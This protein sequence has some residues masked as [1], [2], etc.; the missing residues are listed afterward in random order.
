MQPLYILLC[1]TPPQQ[2]EQIHHF[3]GGGQTDVDRLQHTGSSLSKGKK[4]SKCM[5]KMMS[6]T[7]NNVKFILM[8]NAECRMRKK[9]CIQWQFLIVCSSRC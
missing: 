6:L 3:G 7:P 2:K 9:S 5:C 8:L 4:L 1:T